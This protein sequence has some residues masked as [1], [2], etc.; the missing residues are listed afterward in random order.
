MA[1]ERKALKDYES[2]LV[3]SGY[4]E[5]EIFVTEPSALLTLVAGNHVP[6]LGA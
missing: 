3:E 1:G 6:W 2:A 4:G 5:F